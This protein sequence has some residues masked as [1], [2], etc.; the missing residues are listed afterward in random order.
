[1]TEGRLICVFGAGGQRDRE[2]RPLM[3]R[4]VETAADLP[5]VTDDNPRREDPAR[6]RREIVRGFKWPSGARV[7]ADR[8][9]AIAFALSQAEAGDCVLIAGKGHEEYQLIGSRRHWFD[10]RQVARQWLYDNSLSTDMLVKPWQRA[11]A[12]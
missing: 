9:E 3:G 6:I 5:I 4:V 10:D 1:M 11:R 8:A 2:K 12:A 7:I